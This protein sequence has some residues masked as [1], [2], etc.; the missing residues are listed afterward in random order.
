MSTKAY[1][2]FTLVDVVDG[3][4]WQPDA[5]TAPSNPKEGYAY[6]NTEDKAS[7]IY[8]GQQ[9]N[10]LSKDGEPGDS[11]YSIQLDNDSATI[12]TGADGSYN[13]E[14]LQNVSKVTLKVLQGSEDITSSVG[15]ISWSVSDDEE[16]TLNTT[17]GD[18]V[19]FTALGT[20]TATATATMTIDGETYTKV[21]TISKNKQGENA[22]TYV[23]SVSPNS[24]NTENGSSFP[25]EISVI[26]YIGSTSAP[27]PTEEYE[28]RV[29]NKPFVDGYQVSTTTTFELYVK[30]EQG[31]YILADSETVNVVKNGTTGP[32]G[33]TG[34]IGPTGPKPPVTSTITVYR[35]YGAF[36]TGDIQP[37]GTALGDWTETPIECTTSN[38]FI[39]RCQVTKTT[40]FSSEEDETGTNSYSNWGKPELYQAYCEGIDP[41]RFAEFTTLVNNPDNSEAK[42]LYYNK[43]GDLL[44]NAN[45]IKTG[46]LLVGDSSSPKFSADINN[47]KVII[48]GWN[49]TPHSLTS[50]SSSA[51]NFYAA[52]D[53]IGLFTDF[54]PSELGGATGLAIGNS[55]AKTDWRII[56]GTNFGVDSAGNMYATSGKIG[57]MNIDSI[58]SA[59]D[60]AAAIDELSV[61]GKNLVLQSNISC[62]STEY[63]VKTYNLSEDWELN[64]EYTI[65][66]K[67]VTNS[68]F[69][70]WANGSS[71]NVAYLDKIGNNLYQK[72][73]TTGDSINTQRIKTV[74]IYNTPSGSSR[75]YE[76]SIEWIKIE[77]G[78]LGTDWSPAP[79]DLIAADVNNQFSWNFSPVT[80]LRL[81]K[82]S[83]AS[84]PLF[85]IDGGGLHMVGNGT[86]TGTINANSG[87]IGG[88]KL[89]KWLNNSS[90]YKL[91]S[92]DFGTNGF[93]GMYTSYY[94]TD[95]TNGDLI[96]GHR[97][98]S[99]RLIV[100]NKF[101]VNSEGRLYS[102]GGSFT[103]HIHATS[104]QIGE[105]S[106]E[107]LKHQG[108][109]NLMKNT[110]TV[111]ESS[112]YGVT[113]YAPSSPLVPGEKYTISICAK[114]GQ[115]VK[116][117]APYFSGGY[118]SP[119][120][121]YFTSDVG[122]SNRPEEIVSVTFTMPN[123]HPT[124]HPDSNISYADMTLYRFDSSGVG[125]NT[126]T[127]T[128]TATKIIW[129]K[130]EK[131][132][133][134]TDW[135]P[136][137]EDTTDMNST[138]SWKFDPSNGITMWNGAQT[139]AKRQFQVSSNGLYFWGGSTSQYVRITDTSLVFVNGSGTTKLYRDTDNALKI[140]G[141]VT[142]TT[143]SLL[144]DNSNG[145]VAARDFRAWNGTTYVSGIN[146]TS[147]VTIDWTH[148]TD[149]N[150]HYTTSLYKNTWLKGI[151][152]KSEFVKSLWIRAS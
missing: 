97:D 126:S 95:T 104:G 59:E 64:T 53:R 123:Y 151:L 108:G 102:E 119:C 98:K 150:D 92:G 122:S 49:T 125:N 34:P 46:A 72:T 35:A 60:I 2:S 31:N 139:D 82:G 7:Y 41:V 134:A 56:A 109:R 24:W 145:Y 52:T 10:L 9:W 50:Y 140:G 147:Y 75:V 84:D 32:A 17:E 66:I 4:Q 57:N 69:G 107:G 117:L 110:G 63:L 48:A 65:T 80:G 58:A 131:G 61:G 39:Y 89:E 133:I 54:Q 85:K 83:Q 130:V 90:H 8:D 26:K 62:T 6:Y 144:V 38:K 44:I 143:G 5:A 16:N 128:F 113:S 19:Y 137:P 30:D 88:W 152:V 91:T 68:S 21:F 23:L 112:E 101:G 22:I 129:V 55:G 135:T 71:T 148:S 103:G 28:V 12:G 86:F 116:Y 146:D 120:Q 33:P 25:P 37:T 132:E 18:T 100:G 45:F 118:V 124:Y 67:G 77:K 96:A 78:N 47:N 81:W 1:S 87:T 127:T 141:G 15:T 11:P 14:L 70:A 94:P 36:Q 105:M 115:G 40:T 149:G 20:D 142:L 136:A 3:I 51:R 76:A 111:R 106:I 93:I 73:F 138:Y 114:P 43:N 121:L 42:G 13:Q 99:W 27:A 79:E 29:D 74:E